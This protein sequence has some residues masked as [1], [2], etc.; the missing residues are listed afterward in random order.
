VDEFPWPLY[1]SACLTG[2]V[3]GYVIQRGGFCLTRA[4][5]NAALMGDTTILRAYGLA[6]LVAMVGVQILEVT[7]TIRASL[8]P[9]RWH[10]AACSPS[11]RWAR[12]A[13]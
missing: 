8:T 3:F 11:P 1:I 10:L 2:L 13:G 9:R 12:E 7:G 5:S 6:L 4:V